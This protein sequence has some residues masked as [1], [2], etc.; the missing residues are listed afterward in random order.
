MLKWNRLL[1]IAIATAILASAATAQAQV[2]R[3]SGLAGAG[4]WSANPFKCQTDEGYGRA[5]SC[6]TGGL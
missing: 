3:D 4:I 5:G 1:S 2:R 6:D